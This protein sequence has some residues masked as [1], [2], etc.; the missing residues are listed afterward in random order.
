[1]VIHIFLKQHGYQA[2]PTCKYSVVKQ[3]EPAWKEVLTWKPI[4]Y[5]KVEFCKNEDHIFV[6]VVAYHL[7]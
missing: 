1:M 2:R 4:E 6:E 3:R 5:S 7:W